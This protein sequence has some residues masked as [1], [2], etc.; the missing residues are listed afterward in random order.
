[1]PDCIAIAR[2]IEKREPSSVSSLPSPVMTLPG[3][4]RSSA[5]IVRWRSSLP[6]SVRSS[7][8]AAVKASPLSEACASVMRVTIAARCSIKS[9]VF[10]VRPSCWPGAQ[11]PR[12]GD[13]RLSLDVGE[14]VPRCPIVP[15]TKLAPSPAQG[16]GLFAVGRAASAFSLLAARHRP[17]GMGGVIHGRDFRRSGWQWR[18]SNHLRKWRL[19]SCQ[20]ESA[21]QAHV[22][23]LPRPHAQQGHHSTYPPRPKSAAR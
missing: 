2:T 13:C 9:L 16:I 21:G 5:S 15:H 20:C 11:C 19:D 23:R 4:A 8:S 12:H 18:G 22:P 1:M 17:Q 14:Q 6:S 7:V 10:I 3:S